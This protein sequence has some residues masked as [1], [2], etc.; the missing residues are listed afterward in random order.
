MADAAESIDLALVLAVDCSSSVDKGDFKLQLDGIAAA[1]RHPALLRAVQDGARRQ[2][3]LA[4]LLW[5]NWQSQQ[6]ALPWRLIADAADLEATARTIET[7]GRDI[8]AGGTG[9]AAALDYATALQSVLQAWPAR[10]KI[11]ASGDGMDNEGGDAAAARDRAIARGITV[12]GLP[13]LNGSALLLDYYRDQVIGGPGAFLE[14]TDTVMTFRD[15]MLRKLLREVS[16][17]VS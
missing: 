2:I 13:I 8:P 4:L 3:A 11:D 12:N 17:V 14:P 7:T 10:R 9:L 6:V 15:A 1:L 5:S 16:E